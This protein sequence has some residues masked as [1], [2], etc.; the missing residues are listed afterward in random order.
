MVIGGLICFCGHE[1]ALR[2]Y[3]C[4]PLLGHCPRGCMLLP[5]IGLENNKVK[6]PPHLMSLHTKHTHVN[7]GVR[8]W[9][10]GSATDDRRP[11]VAPGSTWRPTLFMRL[12]LFLNTHTGPDDV[13]RPTH[14]R[15]RPHGGLCSAGGPLSSSAESSVANGVPGF[16]CHQ[17]RLF[18]N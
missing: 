2:D 11:K 16:W 5:A 10:P 9:F 14:C 17:G 12:F 13:V 15:A 6:A 3:H 4:I 7:S 8:C 18:L 1:T